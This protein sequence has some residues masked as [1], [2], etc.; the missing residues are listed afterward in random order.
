MTESTH[1]G[2]REG[3]GYVVVLPG[4]RGTEGGMGEPVAEGHSGVLASPPAGVGENWCRTGLDYLLTNLILWRIFKAE[5]V[6][7]KNRQ[8]NRR[9]PTDEELQARIDTLYDPMTFEDFEQNVADMGIEYGS[10]EW[11]VRMVFDMEY[12]AE[13]A[14]N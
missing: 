14:K 4:K 10:H 1:G 12:A 9:E 6:M 5:Q 13:Y 7:S 2:R 3:A 8:T 11:F